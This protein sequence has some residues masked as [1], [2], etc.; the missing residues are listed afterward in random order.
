M[1]HEPVT[2]A[3]LV[4]N[5]STTKNI[6]VYYGTTATVPYSVRNN[7][8]NITWKAGSYFTF[9]LNEL[10]SI[11]EEMFFKKYTDNVILN[12]ALAYPSNWQM[13]R[14]FFQN[15]FNYIK[16][17]FK[18]KANSFTIL[19]S[20]QSYEP[21]KLDLSDFKLL[22]AIKDGFRADP[23]IIAHKGRN[24]VF[25][26]E[27]LN[28]KDR[29]HISVMEISPNAEY[30]N[31]AIVLEKSYHLSY[32]FIFEFSGD[33]Y[34]IPETSSNRTVELYRAKNFHYE[35][36]FVKNLIE[37][38]ILID[39]TILFEK[40]KW[41]LFANTQSHP[42]TSTN[43]QLMLYYSDDLI[44][45]QW[46]SH[47]QNPIATL[48]SNCRPAGKLFKQN[49]KLYRPA[50][51][52]GSFQYGYGITINEIEIINENEYKEKIVDQ[53]LPSEKNGLSALHSLNFTDNL[54]VIDGIPR[55]KKKKGI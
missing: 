21:G 54:V 5:S 32:P 29:G 1:N 16:S 30:S 6:C 35:W 33:F 41:W 42:D 55:N 7:L 11:G 51:N 8:N 15:T 48:I 26:E 37:D 17:K 46:I 34:M 43:D 9:R 50:Q 31:P 13:T 4:V 39:A 47:P 18:S 22:P 49:G 27:F 40:N 10:L 23:F 12:T 24:Y 28:E 20:F 2:G 38:V 52:N 53:L 25:F 44:S 14:L 45:G 36:E 19:Y 3:M